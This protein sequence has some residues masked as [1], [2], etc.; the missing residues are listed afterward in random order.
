MGY[1]TIPSRKSIRYILKDME[2]IFLGLLLIAASSQADDSFWQM[3]ANWTHVCGYGMTSDWEKCF[4]TCDKLDGTT[5][6]REFLGSANGIEKCKELCLED[7]G[8]S[9]V[10]YWHKL[11]ECYKCIDPSR[12]YPYEFESWSKPMP[13]VVE[14]GS[15]GYEG[16]RL[17]D[18]TNEYEGRLEILFR[19]EWGTVCQDSFEMEDAQ[20]ACKMLGLG[21]AI[22]FVDQYRWPNFGPGSGKVWFD[23][24]MC[25][26]EE[27]NLFDCVH[28][29]VGNGDCN[30]NNDVGVVCEQ[31]CYD[32]DANF[33]GKAVVEPG[34][35]NVLTNI[36][37]AYECQQKCQWDPRC[38]YF[39][40]NSGSGPG[41]WNKNNKNTCWLKRN[42]GKVMR[43]NKDSGKI[44]GPKK[45]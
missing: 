43:R 25:T 29:G 7:S 24:L 3:S 30:H 23:D 11:S 37:S 14:K 36:K 12:V 6:N 45:C 31:P 42:K 18:G 4:C 39:T 8:C 28:R 9:G 1:L 16:I 32:V 27:S 22:G 5:F 38:E 20:V 44:S 26:G 41:R 40:W 21:R 35:D 13:I 17:A 19:G 34:K 15:S 33:K 2:K 10:E